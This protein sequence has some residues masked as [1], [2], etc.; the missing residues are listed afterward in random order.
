[1]RC[2]TVNTG[3]TRCNIATLQTVIWGAQGATVFTGGAWPPGHPLEP[4]LLPGGISGNDALYTVTGK[5]SP[6]KQNA[7][8]C[9]IYN[10]I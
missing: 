8:K 2:H 10:T 3:I 4:P 6:P 7:V 5:N 9:T 1:M